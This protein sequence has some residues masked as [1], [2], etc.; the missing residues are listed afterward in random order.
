MEAGATPGIYEVEVQQIAKVQKVG[1]DTVADAGA[2]L[3]YNG[4]LSLGLDGG[5]AATIVITSDMSLNDIA[6]AINAQGD[7]SNV[8]ASVLQVSEG[9]YMLVLS[10]TETGHGI[11]AA[12]VSG[13]DVLAGLG[14]ASGG[15]FINELQAAQDAILTV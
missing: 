6:D 11:T 13:D 7:T 15:G 8:G 5:E 14:I 4:T 1:S 10:G 12:S 9:E 3:G 2:D